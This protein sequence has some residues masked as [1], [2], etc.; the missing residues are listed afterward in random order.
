MKLKSEKSLEVKNKIVQELR[1]T[2]GDDI[3]FFNK[4]GDEFIV[5]VGKGFARLFFNLALPDCTIIFYDSGKAIETIDIDYCNSIQDIL[6]EIYR[7]IA[8][9]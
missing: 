8:N 9:R 7:V 5:A 6:S 4:Y 2:F 3:R 1:D